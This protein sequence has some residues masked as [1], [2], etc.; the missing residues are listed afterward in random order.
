MTAATF[1]LNDRH[2]IRPAK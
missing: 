1:K 2:S